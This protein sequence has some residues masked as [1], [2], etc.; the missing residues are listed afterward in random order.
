MHCFIRPFLLS[1]KFDKIIVTHHLPKNNVA[2]QRECYFLE[3]MSKIKNYYN[4]I[5]KKYTALFAA[6]TY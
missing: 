6:S 1:I 5:I 4:I 2:M 3:F